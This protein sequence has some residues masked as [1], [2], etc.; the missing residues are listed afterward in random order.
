MD[1]EDRGWTEGREEERREGEKEVR[2]WTGEEREERV[3]ERG[4]ERV[5]WGRERGDGMGREREEGKRG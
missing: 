2:G 1:R 3:R 4:G 5:E